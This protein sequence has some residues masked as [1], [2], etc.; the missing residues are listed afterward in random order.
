MRNIRD[1]PARLREQG[2]RVTPNRLAVLAVLA[3]AQRPQSIQ[4]ITAR[5]K[6]RPFKVTVYRVLADLK[7]AGLV[8]Q[9]D[10]QQAHAYFELEDPDDH[11]HLVCVKCERV[12]DFVGCEADSLATKALK[13]SKRFA[14]VT[15]HSFELFGLCKSCKVT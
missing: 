15:G 3:A 14:T 5:L 7:K 4:Q 12:E 9:V 10:F 13:Q 2:L 6:T 11:H 8:R 1:Y